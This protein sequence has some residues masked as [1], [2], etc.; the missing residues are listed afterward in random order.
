M[1]EASTCGVNGRRLWRVDDRR[2]VD[3][4]GLALG[5]TRRK[6]F[7][8]AQPLSRS[9]V[10]AEL[11]RPWAAAAR[12]PGAGATAA[13]RPP[14]GPSRSPK[15]APIF[16]APHGQSCQECSELRWGL[17]RA[18]H[19]MGQGAPRRC[20]PLAAWIM[21]LLAAFSGLTAAQKK[22][23]GALRPQQRPACRAPLLPLA[24]CLDPR[25]ITPPPLFQAR[26]LARWVL[27]VTRRAPAARSP[28]PQ[29]AP[30]P[31]LRI[32]SRICMSLSWQD[33]LVGNFTINSWPCIGRLLSGLPQSFCL[34][35]TKHS[36]ACCGPASLLPS[37]PQAACP[38]TCLQCKPDGACTGCAPGAMRDPANPGRC[39]RCA[40]A[41]CA[42]C[43][44]SPGTCK[45]CAAFLSYLNI[46]LPWDQDRPVYLDPSTGKCTK[47]RAWG[48]QRRRRC[49]GDGDA[50][51]PGGTG[52]A[53]VNSG[54]R[55]AA[56]SL[57]HEPWRQQ[58]VLAALARPEAGT[59]RASPARSASSGSSTGAKS[60]VPRGSAL[61]AP[62][63]L[64][65]ST[66]SASRWVLRAAE[67]RSA[68]MRGH[69]WL[70]ALSSGAAGQLSAVPAVARPSG[71]HPPNAHTGPRPLPLRSSLQCKGGVYCDSCAPGTLE[72]RKCRSV[73]GAENW[74]AG[75]SLPLPCACRC[76]PD[77]GGGPF[78]AALPCCSA[79][80]MHAAMHPSLPACS[81]PALPPFP[82]LPLPL[83]LQGYVWPRPTRRVRQVQ[84]HPV[85]VLPR[86]LQ[87]VHQVLPWHLPHEQAE[88]RAGARRS[89][90]PAAC[91]P[92]PRQPRLLPAAER[93]PSVRAV[94]HA[95]RPPPACSCPWAART[96]THAASAPPAYQVRRKHRGC[97]LAH[98]KLRPSLRY[99]R[100][101][102][103]GAGVPRHQRRPCSCLQASTSFGA[104]PAAANAPRDAWSAPPPTSARSAAGTT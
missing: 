43:G 32:M 29:G 28:P 18:L 31:L 42:T 3:E 85:R 66:M 94:P 79:G 25:V 5:P 98:S 75:G 70:G 81:L 39:V 60:A 97:S 102:C 16:S 24:P 78:P 52:G 99:F 96:R 33:S 90:Q 9:A 54:A 93:T 13:A 30:A 91:W 77:L 37:S 53:V 7:H 63:A 80:C 61:A 20:G 41:L 2:A 23:E 86:G 34:G 83:S 64:G 38:S 48:A 87:S 56:G 14:G 58:L 74:H 40:D 65:W 44:P 57:L 68:A 72:C 8:T 26:W 15:L 22:N 100:A 92:L 84:R 10:E 47:V 35:R 89:L 101:L 46:F 49:W 76:G 11:R 55:R 51:G 62:R 12:C 27:C 69:A 45:E 95:R 59:P 104:S 67:S 36:H 6:P 71:A 21:L 50:L 4:T 88:M 73:L 17:F 19:A 1:A 82:S 103:W